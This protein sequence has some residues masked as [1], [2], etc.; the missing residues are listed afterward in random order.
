MTADRSEAVALLEHGEAVA[1]EVL[2]QNA[3]SWDALSAAD[4]ARVEM[5]ARS[6]AERLLH[7][8]AVNL[9]A[10]E[11]AGDQARVRLTRDLFGF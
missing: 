10:A 6:L 8:P 9:A 7:E 1:A 4:R 11:R 5:L 2:A 3:R